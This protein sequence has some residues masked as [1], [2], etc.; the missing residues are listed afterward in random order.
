MS[1]GLFVV[2]G[3]IIA[4]MIILAVCLLNGKGASLIAGYNDMSQD[5][6]AKYDEK[7]LCRSVGRMLIGISVGILLVPVGIHF[8][9]A[10][11]CYG[12]IAFVL[13][14]VVGYTI[15]ANTGNR[16]R[17]NQNSETPAASE[18]GVPK[19]GAAKAAILIVIVL[20]AIT[21]TAIGVS[22]YQGDKD[23]VVNVHSGGIEIKAIYG[24]NLDFADI[25]VI[26]ILEE[27]MRDLGVGKKTNGYNGIEGA[28]KGNFASGDSG[29]ALLFV[30]SDASP[31]IRIKRG[32]AQ[33]IYI[34]FR[35]ADKTRALYKEMTEAF[36]N[37]A[38]VAFISPSLSSFDSS[39]TLL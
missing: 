27:S 20:S 19:S 8:E 1:A 3:V 17:I 31:T 18:N 9:T 34:S 14:D 24:L 30:Q 35:N 2:F 4:P 29:E 13:S 5:E 23:P 16:F 12:G 6:K 25:T 38:S 32:G 21:L 39:T 22:V 7:A 36:K 28:L 15:Y 11:L 37:Y 10:W 26:S 33:D